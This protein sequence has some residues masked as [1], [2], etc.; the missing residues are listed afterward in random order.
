VDARPRHRCS[1][2]GCRCEL[3]TRWGARTYIR[4]EGGALS[5]VAPN[6]PAVRV[7]GALVR[8]PDPGSGTTVRTAAAGDSWS[9]GPAAWLVWW[10]RR[11]LVVCITTSV[12]APSWSMWTQTVSDA[13]FARNRVD[14]RF[15]VDESGNLDSPF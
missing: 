7:L 2:C 15:V 8:A 3:L 9:G 12:V 6:I 10:Y 5:V 14:L 13:A 11:N 4:A 1:G